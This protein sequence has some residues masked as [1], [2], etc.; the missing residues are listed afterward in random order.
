M[1]VECIASCGVNLAMI[2]VSSHAPPFLTY[3]VRRH[4]GGHPS[5]A[6]AVE[7]CRAGQDRQGLRRQHMAVL[8]RACCRRDTTRR[9]GHTDFA[10]V[11]QA[12][13][14]SASGFAHRCQSAH[15]PSRRRGPGWWRRPERSRTCADR[16]GKK[17]A[18]APKPRATFHS[19][20]HAV[21]NACCH[22]PGPTEGSGDAMPPTFGSETL[23]SP[24][25][26]AVCPLPHAAT[27]TRQRLTFASTSWAGK[28]VH[29][30]TCMTGASLTS[31]NAI[32]GARQ[33]GQA[34]CTEQRTSL[35]VL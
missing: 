23:P 35:L 27:A 18:G 29:A 17:R 12:T 22:P 4:Q 25:Y 33:H 13:V 32:V 7:G 11:F 5:N 3:A 19:S 34:C 26:T 8:G 15:R 14:R 6:R 21:R 10:P 31:C 24:E 1:K 20:T 16:R 9:R 2:R 28:V 30:N